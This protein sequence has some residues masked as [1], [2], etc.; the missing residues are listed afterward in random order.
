MHVFI[1]LLL[2]SELSSPGR[3]NLVFAEESK[4]YGRDSVALEMKMY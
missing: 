4:S 2:A 1:T 3:K